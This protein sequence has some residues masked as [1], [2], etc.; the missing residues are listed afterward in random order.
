MRLLPLA[1]VIIVLGLAFAPVS[2]AGEDGNSPGPTQ[3]GEVQGPPAQ[4]PASHQGPSTARG[5]STS[6][7]SVAGAT[8]SV[9]HSTARHGVLGTQTALRTQTTGI[10]AG[11]GGAS[12]S[13][14][15]GAALGIALVGGGMLLLAAAG[16]GLVPLRRRSDG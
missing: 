8:H 11:L 13:S 14:S 1:A 6:S 12:V 2:F 3:V 10:Q 9:S 16:S 4:S 5:T 7:S 15:T